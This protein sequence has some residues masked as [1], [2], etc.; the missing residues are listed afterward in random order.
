MPICNTFQIAASAIDPISRGNLCCLNRFK[1]LL[2]YIKNV[3][4]TEDIE[5]YKKEVHLYVN[6]LDIRHIAE[7]PMV[8]MCRRNW[9][10]WF[11]AQIRIYFNM[12][13]W[14]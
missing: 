10:I 14:A 12:F 11:T 13:S 2:K 3:I 6:D 1:S 9:K 5:S 4:K 7:Q 8:E